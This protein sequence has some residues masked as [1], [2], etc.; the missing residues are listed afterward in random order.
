MLDDGGCGDAR[1]AASDG[2]GEDGAG[3]VVAREDLADAAVGDPQLPADVTGPDPELGQL[4][5]P[6]SDGVGERPAVHE[7]PA[8]L[9]DLAE[10]RFWWPKQTTERS[11]SLQHGPNTHVGYPDVWIFT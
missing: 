1:L 9:V 10:G 2:P 3:L 4:H 6:E 5:Y 8:E 11:E 7:N